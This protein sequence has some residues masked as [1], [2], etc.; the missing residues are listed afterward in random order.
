MNS[1]A[2]ASLEFLIVL[3]AFFSLLLIFTPMIA[4]IHHTGILALEKKRAQNFAE[5][6][7]QTL[8]EFSLLANGSK[9]QLKIKPLL[10]WKITA[11]NSLHI[12]LHS[13]ELQKTSEINHQ[14]PIPTNYSQVTCTEECTFQIQK[15]FNSIQVTVT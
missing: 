8:E 6:F 4:K 12:E 10:E 1:K 9:K 5:E 13:E 3:T 7:S 2:Q 11:S 15:Q 14:L